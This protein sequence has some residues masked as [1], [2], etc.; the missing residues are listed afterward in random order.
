MYIFGN[1]YFETLILKNTFQFVFLFFVITEILIW[2]FTGISSRKQV[3]K[4]ERGDKGSYFLIV[5][6]N[7]ATIFI[8]VLSRKKLAFNLPVLFFWIGIILTITGVLLR[9]FS[10]WTLRHFF[11]LSVQVSSVQNIVQNGPY[12]Y[13]R[14]PAYTGNILTFTGFAM[15]FRSLP[16]I[17]GTLIILAFIYA[18]RIKVE[19]NMLENKLGVSYRKY[20]KTTWKIIPF[21]W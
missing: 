9:V 5:A 3:G 16:G 21:M 6:G 14:H 10:V 2:C 7:T 19:E 18:Y 8:D 11:T 15:A 4:K 1:S 13:L 12:K 20:K 17:L